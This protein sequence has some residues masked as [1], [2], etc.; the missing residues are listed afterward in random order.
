[1]FCDIDSTK[2]AEGFYHYCKNCGDSLVSRYPTIMREC[3]GKLFKPQPD[4][5]VVIHRLGICHQCSD[6][7][8]TGCWKDRE[9]GCTRE[10]YQAAQ[11]A[12]ESGSCPIGRLAGNLPSTGAIHLPSIHT[13]V[14]TVDKP[15]CTRRHPRVTEILDGFGFTDW[16]FFWG[17]PGNPYWQAIRPEYASLL[18]ENEPPFLILE[19]DIAVRDFQPWVSYPADAECVY[20][21][22]GGAWAGS[23][24]VREAKRRLP[25]LPIRKVRE[26]GMLDLDE[27]WVRVF[28]MFG[29]H[30]MLHIN[31][32]VMLEMAD[33]IDSHNCPVDVAFG[34]NQWRWNCVL[35]RIPMFWQ[36]DGHNGPGTYNYEPLPPEPPEPQEQRIRRLR[37]T[38]QLLLNR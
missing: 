36:N 34:K 8:G 14:Y 30:A 38:R 33:C 19:D 23:G 2:A 4:H 32:R 28:G 18:R 24:L 1:M 29:T 37:R 6:H 10:R 25:N 21:G 9:Y 13:V 26:I 31:K 16:S 35:R 12:A 3:S 7:P 27:T 17:K 20:L 22:G 15:N 11:R 5:F